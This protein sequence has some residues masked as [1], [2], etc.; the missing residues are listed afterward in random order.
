MTL[1]ETE[2]GILTQ[3][4]PELQAQGYDVFVRPTPTVIPSFLGDYQ[5]D[6]IAIR[7]AKNAASDKNLVIE[8]SKEASGRQK[9]LDQVAKLVA[10][11]AGWELRIIWI[12]PATTFDAMR[13]QSAEAIAD[14][15]EEVKRLASDG[16]AA[17]ALLLGWAILEAQARSLET[18]K[19]QRPQT[20]GRLVQTLAA[21]GH[22]TPDEADTLRPIAYKRNTLAHGDLAEEVSRHDV[23]ELIRIL[24]TLQGLVP[25]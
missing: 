24:L 15:I 5:P 9:R 7:T 8:V 11:H 25:A 18:E 12:S 4:V 21:N 6:A 2:I 14:R 22:L 3:V 13:V 20:S 23:D 19:F 1:Q 16:H 10:D 17:A